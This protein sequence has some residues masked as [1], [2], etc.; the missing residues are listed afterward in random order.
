MNDTG[1]STIE[2]SALRIGASPGWLVVAALAAAVF[3]FVIGPGV[4][5][6]GLGR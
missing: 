3:V 6:S 1:A 5:L 2:E 4:D